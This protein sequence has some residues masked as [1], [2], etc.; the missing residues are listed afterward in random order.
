MCVLLT[1][2]TNFMDNPCRCAGGLKK[3]LDLRSGSQGHRHFVGFFNVPVLAPTRDH[4]FHRHSK[5]HHII[6]PQHTMMVLACINHV[7]F[8]NPWVKYLGSYTICLSV[9]GEILTDQNFEQ[10]DLEPWYS[11]HILHQWNDF[12]RHLGNTFDSLVSHMHTQGVTGW[13]TLSNYMSIAKELSRDH[14]E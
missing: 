2:S 5:M 6:S 12:K 7:D 14:N 1:V 4:P 9:C 10:I 11:A 13:C 3:K 8:H